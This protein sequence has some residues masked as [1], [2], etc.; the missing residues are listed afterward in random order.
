MALFDG[1]TRAL[2]ANLPTPSLTH[3]RFCP[4][5]FAL[6]NLIFAELSASNSDPIK[7]EVKRWEMHSLSSM[8]FFCLVSSRQKP[9]HA[10]IHWHG[11]GCRFVGHF[12][13]CHYHRVVILCL[14]IADDAL[15]VRCRPA[16]IS[17]RLVNP[18]EVNPDRI[19]LSQTTSLLFAASGRLRP[20]E[21][22]M[23][24]EPRDAGAWFGD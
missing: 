14:Q 11:S 24:T 3:F 4:P 5:P 16:L 12:A 10:C 2:I 21:N 15:S 9:L 13:C 8:Q 6:R 1:S 19:H 23:T 20:N 7:R 22:E 17:G 18:A